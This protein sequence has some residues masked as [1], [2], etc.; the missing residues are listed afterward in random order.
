MTVLLM[1]FNFVILS[2]SI[3]LIYYFSSANYACCK[4]CSVARAVNQMCASESD[5]TC[6]MESK[7][8]GISKTCPITYRP[9]GEACQKE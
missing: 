5:F 6:M 3:L 2:E 9:P 7:C 1:S 8:D 4:D